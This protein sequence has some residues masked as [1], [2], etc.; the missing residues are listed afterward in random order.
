MRR[1]VNTYGNHPSFAFFGI[2]NELGGSDFNAMKQWVKDIKD[3][4]HRHLYA[5]STARAITNEDDFNITHYIPDVGGTYGVNYNN[6]WSN[7]DKNYKGARIPII[8]HEIGQ[9]PVYPV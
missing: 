8:A 5:V 1:V 7:H 6:S 2:G 4:D 9:Y 3:I